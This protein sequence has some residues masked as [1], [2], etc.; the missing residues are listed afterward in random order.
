MYS[1]PG[2]ARFSDSSQT[3]AIVTFENAGEYVLILKATDDI[4]SPSFDVV[5]VKVGATL[6]ASIRREGSSFRLEW[7]GPEG[8]YTLES[9]DEI[10]GEW[11]QAATL[12]ATNYVVPEQ[13]TRK[14]FRVRR[15]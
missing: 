8:S 15:D 10:D 4:H 2:P 14:F 9:V 11:K 7:T 6:E 3:N 1:G 5:R 12:T 13:T